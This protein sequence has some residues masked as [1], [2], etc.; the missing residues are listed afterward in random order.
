[1]MV[2][3]VHSSCWML[4]L[5]SNEDTVNDQ[6][7]PDRYRRQTRAGA[8]NGAMRSR[9]RSPHPAQLRRRHHSIHTEIITYPTRAYGKFFNVS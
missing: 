2:G 6:T 8:S 9:M 7:V 4:R 1:M 3:G 5:R